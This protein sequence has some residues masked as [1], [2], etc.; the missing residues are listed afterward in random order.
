MKLS[1]LAVP[2]VVLTS[3]LLSSCQKEEKGV[4]ELARELSSELAAISD[5]ATADARAARVEVLNKRLQNAAARTLALNGTA[6]R[7][8]DD[9]DGSAYAKALSVLA[10]EVGRVRASYPAAADAE[11][12]DEEQLFI[13][14]AV[15]QGG[16]GTPDELKE[17]GRAYMTDEV[18]SHETPGEFPE[19]FGSE[20]L[21]AALGY[22][23]EP[24]E[25]SGLQFDSEDAPAV[26][27]LKEVEE[28]VSADA[29]DNADAP[30]EEEETDAA[31]GEEG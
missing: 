6:L 19:Y 22:R 27:A 18:N 12:P 30:S 5:T 31:E 29:G 4:V 21:K 11:A 25:V 13:A 7:R 17:A 3:I 28:S 15:A 10:R 14:I 16:K 9:E 24:S 2:C 1:F 20:A 23:V 26:P 8:S